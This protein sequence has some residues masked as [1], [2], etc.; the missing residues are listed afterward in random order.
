MNLPHSFLFF[1]KKMKI[2]FNYQKAQNGLFFLVLN[3]IIHDASLEISNII[4]NYYDT[5]I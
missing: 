5:Y 4:R 3:I 2:K 1:L